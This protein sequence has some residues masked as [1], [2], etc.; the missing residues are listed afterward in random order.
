MPARGIAGFWP[1]R[2]TD[3]KPRF[4]RSLYYLFF[5]GLCLIATHAGAQSADDHIENKDRLLLFGYVAA[6]TKHA[7]KPHL[8]HNFPIAA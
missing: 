3:L 8:L 7:E 6:A 5:V 2:A 4:I 1:N